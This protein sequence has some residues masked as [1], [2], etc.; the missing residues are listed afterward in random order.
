MFKTGLTS[1]FGTDMFLSAMSLYCI[2]FIGGYC[3]VSMIIKNYESRKA[4][5]KLQ[6]FKLKD[7][8]L[9][10]VLAYQKSYDMQT[11]ASNIVVANPDGKIKVSILTNPHCLPCSRMHKRLKDVSSAN[12]ELRIEYIFT[13]FSDELEDSAY[14][15]IYNYFHNSNFSDVLDEWFETGRN[16]R[17]EFYNKYSFDK[18]DSI[19]E[20]EIQTHKNWKKYSDLEAT[21]TVLVNGRVLP[22]DYSVEDLKYI[23]SL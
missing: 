16:K 7:T 15:L 22:S 17:R 6:I 3:V 20:T 18:K 11:F 19:T 23:T 10:A 4:I 13:S 9:R 12:K 8:T 14:C 21:P 2:L 1:G 5:N